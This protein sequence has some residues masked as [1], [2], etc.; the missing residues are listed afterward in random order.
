MTKNN[1]DDNRGKHRL[2]TVG[3]EFGLDC[4]ILEYIELGC[5]QVRPRFV[6]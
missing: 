1:T 2:I 4:D 6:D 3:I 5:V